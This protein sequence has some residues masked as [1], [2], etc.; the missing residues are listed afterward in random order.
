MKI[1]KVF[2]PD[3]KFLQI[4]SSF[5]W[6]IEPAFGLLEFLRSLVFTAIMNPEFCWGILGIPR[7]PLK[8]G[9]FETSSHFALK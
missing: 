2:A 7:A 5:N 6:A 9:S 4:G 8:Q 3:F 1:F